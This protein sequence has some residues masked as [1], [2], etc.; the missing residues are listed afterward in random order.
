MQLCFKPQVSVFKSILAIQIRSVERAFFFFKNN[1]K[2]MEKKLED[3]GRV[4][5]STAGY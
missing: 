2:V 1:E 4:V 5:S 3:P